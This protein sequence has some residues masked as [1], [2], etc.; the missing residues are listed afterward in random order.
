MK[1]L[2]LFSLFLFIGTKSCLA[3][4]DTAN[5]YILMDETTGRVLR[6]KNY[7]TPMLIASITKIL[8]CVLA[9]ESS[10]LDDIVTVDETINESYGS[11]IYIE[12]DEEIKLRDLLYGLMLRSGND[13]ALM[14]AKYIGGDIETFVEKMNIKA[15]EIGMTNSHFENPSGLDNTDSGNYSTAYD[16]ALLTRYAMQYEEYKKIVA[17]K[18]Y[19]VKTNKKEYVWK[20]KNKLLNESYITGGKTGYTEKARR[21]LVSTGSNNNMNFIVV[22]INDSD[23]WNTHKSL[24][25]YA[26]SNYKAYRI[27]N[28]RNFTIIGEKH[29]NGTFY[30]NNDIII[31]FNEKELNNLIGKIELEKK[32]HY[33][34]NDKVGRYLIYL[35][36]NLIYDEAIYIKNIKK[37]NNKKNIFDIL[38][39]VFK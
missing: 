20:N 28:K 7:H 29:Y 21:T 19:K 39:G 31:P 22:T 30:I 26:F 17:T 6:G 34:N 15:Q 16:M 10:K 2:L 5:Q 14:I 12:V 1:K 25:S 3:S 35:D 38:K 32:K 11:G 37:K 27:L 24:Y 33:S 18:S 23:D 8:T 9:I 36:E 4:I 13:A